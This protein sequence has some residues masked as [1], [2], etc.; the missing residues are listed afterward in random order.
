MAA[1]NLEVDPKHIEA[2]ENEEPPA[3]EPTDEDCIATST[4]NAR[5][6]RNENGDTNNRAF[7]G[8]VVE[9][10]AEEERRAEFSAT[11]ATDKNRTTTSS[12]VTTENNYQDNS[13]WPTTEEHENEPEAGEGT[14]AGIGFFPSEEGPSMDDFFHNDSYNDDP[15]NEGQE[16]GTS[17][18]KETKA[19][20]PPAAS[21]AAV[22]LVPKKSNSKSR[23][24]K[25]RPSSR[26]KK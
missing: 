5:S 23:R 2:H 16:E 9:E 11:L 4:N 20:E 3:Y 1:L 22:S 15:M 26:R 13:F 19:A 21:T 24:P 7:E 18:T 10:D 8:E 6:A 25:I 14:D 17:A 12:V